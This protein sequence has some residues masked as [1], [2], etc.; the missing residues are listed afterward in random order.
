MCAIAAIGPSPGWL[1][2]TFG[3]RDTRAGG[4]G[5]D[6]APKP[7][8][9]RGCSAWARVGPSVT[10]RRGTASTRSSI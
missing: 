9:G 2:R 7:A 8:V 4:G 3:V 1:A 10:R 5:F 6:A